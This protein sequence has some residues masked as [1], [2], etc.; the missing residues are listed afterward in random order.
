MVNFQSDIDA[1]SLLA[2]PL[3]RHSPPE[4]VASLRYPRTV[5]CSATATWRGRGVTELLKAMG[6]HRVAFLH[7]KT[8][9]AQ[10]STT[11]EL[12]SAM[13]ADTGCKRPLKRGGV[14]EL[15]QNLFSLVLL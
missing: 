1:N 12:K 15:F 8:V 6:W 2:L 9:A 13:A 3:R 14:P 7:E 10:V 4:L 11:A 5:R